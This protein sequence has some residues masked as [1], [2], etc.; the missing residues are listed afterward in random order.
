MLSKCGLL[1]IEYLQALEW[2]E[3]CHQETKIGDTHT[4]CLHQQVLLL[5]LREAHS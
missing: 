3:L 4:L 2:A 1:F 5:G